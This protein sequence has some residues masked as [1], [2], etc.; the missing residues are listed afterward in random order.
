MSSNNQLNGPDLKSCL[1]GCVILTAIALKYESQ[2]TQILFTVLV[3]AGVGALI[4]GV[5]CF[6]REYRKRLGTLHLPTG[7]DVDLTGI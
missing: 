2:I 4:F 3:I 6:A 5:W 7:T 1:I